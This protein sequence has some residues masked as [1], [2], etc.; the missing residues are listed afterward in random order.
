MK[1]EHFRIG[2]LIYIGNR[3]IKI[4]MMH[5]EHFSFLSDNQWNP[6]LPYKRIEPI[7]I[8][9]YWLLK[10]GFEETY[11]SNSRIRYDHSFNFIGYDFSK[12]ED[13]DMEGFRFYG[14]YIK[15]KYVHQLQNLF[16]AL[17]GEELE[18]N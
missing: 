8:T 15:I 11:N 12:N 17:T 3:A 18:L 6:M 1:A 16:F 9:D 13:K 2:N 7:E 10:F 4:G 14:K 5:D